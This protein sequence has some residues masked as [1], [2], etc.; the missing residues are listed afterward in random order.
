MKTL[1]HIGN[2]NEGD[3]LLGEMA[4]DHVCL[5]TITP[6][7][8][9]RSVRYFDTGS[10]EPLQ[11]SLEE[12]SFKKV[13]IGAAY[14][15]AITTPNRYFDQSKSDNF[16]LEIYPAEHKLF[17]NSVVNEWQV[18][19]S[20]ALPI[21]IQTLVPGAVIEHVYYCDLK[22]TFGVDQEIKLCFG[23]KYFRAVVKK[24]NTLQ[25][26]QMYPYQT[27][28]DVTYYLLNIGYQLG[29]DQQQT[30][31]TLSGL[32]DQDSNLYKEIYQYFTRVSFDQVDGLIESEYP[33][34]YFTS[35]HQ[36]AKCAL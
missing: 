30:Q 3:I 34:H 32:I 1:F 36:L 13:I 17:R 29:M 8:A 28:L 15:E 4:A 25:L 5:A 31:L 10:L 16:L 6:D 21:E 18:T 35:I 19:I 27:P 22:R 23:P 11:K 7:N 2:I 20:Y 12:R 26:C 33:A 14:P 9:I 24:G